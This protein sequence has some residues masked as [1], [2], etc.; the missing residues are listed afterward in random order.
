MS[1]SCSVFLT[2]R[3]KSSIEAENGFRSQLISSLGVENI[4]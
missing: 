3:S 4:L 2:G 1:I